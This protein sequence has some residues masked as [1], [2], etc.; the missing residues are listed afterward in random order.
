MVN[1]Q[2]TKERLG[3]GSQ[4]RVGDADGIAWIR[5]ANGGQWVDEMVCSRSRCA[6]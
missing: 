4:F 1:G 2:T 5:I 6:W 3:R